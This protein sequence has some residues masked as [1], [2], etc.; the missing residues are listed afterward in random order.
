MFP[1][2][3]STGGPEGDG[4]NARGRGYMVCWDRFG[5]D[6]RRCGACCYTPSMLRHGR[7]QPIVAPVA[8]SIIADYRT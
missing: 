7:V 3:S 4:E 1:F 5:A 2:S 6:E 8:M